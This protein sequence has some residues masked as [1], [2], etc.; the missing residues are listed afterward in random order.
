MSVYRVLFVDD[1]PQVLSSLGGYFERLGHEV[2]RAADGREGVEVWNRV[3]PD[4]TV[5]DLHMP[6]MDGMQVLEILRK[7]NAMVI[8]LTGYGEI[9]NAVEA[10][11]LGAENFLTKPV[12]MSHLV[13]AVEKAAEKS[14]LRREVVELR[15]RLR[16]SV[17]RRIMRFAVFAVLLAAAIAIGTF[18]GGGEAERPM[19]PIP[20]PIDTAP[21]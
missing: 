16:P 21:G 14:G 6:G 17:K 10:M 19:A 7:E 8:V 18:I 13:Q 4:V 11:R 5:L 9:E 1:D 20:V 2:Y 15:E 12:E 3:E